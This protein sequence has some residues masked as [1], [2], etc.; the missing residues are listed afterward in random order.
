MLPFSM[1]VM[2]AC[3][4]HTVASDT[5]HAHALSK[6]AGTGPCTGITAVCARLYIHLLVPHTMLVSEHFDIGPDAASG[7]VHQN[8]SQTFLAPSCGWH[9]EQS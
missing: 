5:Q 7:C 3:L 6:H 2:W 8:A 1:T 9:L 4:M